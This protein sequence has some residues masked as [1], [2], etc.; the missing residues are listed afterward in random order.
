MKQETDY[1]PQ[2][3]QIVNDEGTL[4]ILS[5]FELTSEDDRHRA[6]GITDEDIE[7]EDTGGME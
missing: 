3:Y 6:N 4:K 1:R 5:Y 2:Y 7:I